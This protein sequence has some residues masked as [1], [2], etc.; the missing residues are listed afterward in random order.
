MIQVAIHEPSVGTKTTRPDRPRAGR[1]LEARS[2]VRLGKVSKKTANLKDVSS[3]SL[4]M[5]YM[6][7]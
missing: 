4:G 5:P 6:P 1:R 2:I 3:E 7:L